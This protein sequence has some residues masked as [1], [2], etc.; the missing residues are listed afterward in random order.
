MIARPKAP[1]VI[2]LELSHAEASAIA[3]ALARAR[4]PIQAAGNVLDIQR[5]KALQDGIEAA[6]EGS[7]HHGEV[8]S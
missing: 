5:L 6:L 1:P 2:V 7:V 8:E 3:R 4:E